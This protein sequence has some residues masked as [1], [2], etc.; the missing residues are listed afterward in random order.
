MKLYIVVMPWDYARAEVE[1][2]QD[3]QDAVEYVKQLDKRDR[4]YVYIKEVDI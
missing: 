1:V 4:S 3:K 2:F